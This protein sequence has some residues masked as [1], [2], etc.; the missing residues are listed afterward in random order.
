MIEVLNARYPSSETGA[1]S[2]SEILERSAHYVAGFLPT[3]R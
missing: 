2:S 3:N 1:H